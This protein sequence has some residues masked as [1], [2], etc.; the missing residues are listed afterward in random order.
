MS[1]S[2]MS[3]M[4]KSSTPRHAM[5]RPELGTIIPPA[6]DSVITDKHTSSAE[7]VQVEHPYIPKFGSPKM[8]GCDASAGMRSERDE[9]SP[10]SSQPE[11]M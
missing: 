2:G 7:Y 5:R 10:T 1:V 6:V 3:T 11:L 9:K 4:T 8:R